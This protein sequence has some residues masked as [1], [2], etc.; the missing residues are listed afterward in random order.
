VLINDA[1]QRRAL[2][3]TRLEVHKICTGRL[4]SC[5]SKATGTT[6]YIIDG[7]FPR[8]PKPNLPTFSV[9][10]ERERG[11]MSCAKEEVLRSVDLDDE[12]REASPGAPTHTK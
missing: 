1:G 3:K 7:V 10:V 6:K 12:S 11:P 5:C 2:R 8:S 4:T 9:H